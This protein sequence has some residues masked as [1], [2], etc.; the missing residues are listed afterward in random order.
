MAT[1]TISPDQ[2]KLTVDDQQFNFNPISRD[3]EESEDS[4]NT[5]AA[6]K[7]CVELQDTVE[8]EFPFPCFDRDDGE[9]GNFLAG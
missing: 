5:C 6:Y 1:V 3:T 2:N 8:S 7:L 4:C 9:M